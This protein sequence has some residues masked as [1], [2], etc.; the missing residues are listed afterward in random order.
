MR[1]QRTVSPTAT[2]QQLIDTI[3]ADAHLRL[4]SPSLSLG[5]TPL[6]IQAPEALRRALAGNLEKPLSALCSEG[7][8]ITVTDP[9]FGSQCALELTLKFAA[10]L[11]AAAAAAAAAASA[12]SPSR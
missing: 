4:T 10:P 8:V 9:S 5:P 6:Y 1:A 3:T 2:L 11:A 12:P 7:D